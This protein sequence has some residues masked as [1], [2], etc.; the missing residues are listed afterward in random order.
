[1]AGFPS[2]ALLDEKHPLY[3]L[4]Q[5]SLKSVGKVG[6]EGFYKQNLTIEV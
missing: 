1:M 5:H 2:L 4:T 6:I 3:S